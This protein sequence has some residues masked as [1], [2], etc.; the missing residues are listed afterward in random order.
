[1][2]KIKSS[3]NLQLLEIIKILK[4]SH[5]TIKKIFSDG[6][7]YEFYRFLKLLY[8][9]AE[10]W[11]DGNHV[12]TKIDDTFY[13]INGVTDFTDMG[14]RGLRLMTKDDHAFAALWA[15]EEYNVDKLKK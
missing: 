5:V 10:A 8:P 4:H 12:Y 14:S 2:A 3:V 1:M 11:Y 7:C 9:N 15:M 13:D 6:A